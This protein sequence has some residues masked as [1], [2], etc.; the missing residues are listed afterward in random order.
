MNAETTHLLATQRFIDLGERPDLRRTVEHLSRHNLL[1]KVLP[2]IWSTPEL[3]A[4]ADVRAAAVQQRHRDAV[5]I[6]DTAAWLVLDGPA[7]AVIEVSVS[8]HLRPQ[9]GFRFSEKQVPVEDI[10]V[11]HGLRVHSPAGT[12]VDLAA[13]DNGAAIDNALRLGRAQLEGLHRVMGS[14]R[15]RRGNRRRREI[16]A[17]SRD[18]P[19]SAAERVAHR[20]LRE[21]QLTGWVTNRPILTSTGRYLADLVFSV[22]RLIVEIDGYAT[23]GTR[24]AFESDRERQNALV[25]DGWRVLRFTWRTLTSQPDV[26]LA[27]IRHALAN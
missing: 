24:N 25:L 21:S 12:A 22:A 20:L 2:N 27:Q 23:H 17:D 16:L 26:F 9:Q 15:G 6:G 11:L 19:W 18:E 1:V 5:L 8:G 13:R 3:A 10:V 4:R 14:I 7:P